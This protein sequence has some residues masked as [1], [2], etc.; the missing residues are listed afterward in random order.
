MFKYALYVVALVAGVVVS[1]AACSKR[2][3]QQVETEFYE[4]N[5][6]GGDDGRLLR[7]VNLNNQGVGSLRWALAQTGA[8]KIIFDVGGVIDL[9]EKSLKIREAHVTIAGETAPSPG[10]TLIKGGLRI[11]TH[12]V[13]V[14]HLMIRPGDAG[15]SKGQGWKPDG[16]TI[17]GSKARHVVIDH[18]SVTWAV[19]E[20]IAV[21]GPADKGAEATAGKVLI[22]NSIIAEALSNA[23]HPEG[24]HSKGILIHNNVQHVSLVNNLLAH[25]RR[26]NPYFKAGTTGI[27]IGNIIYNPGKRAIHMSSGRADASLPTLSITGNLFIPAANTSPNLSL[28]SNY[29]KI[30]SSGNLVQGESRPITDGKSISLTAPPLQQVGINLTDTG[31]QNDFCQTLS[32]AGARPWDPDPIDIRIKTQLL[33]GEGRIIDSQSEV[34]GYPIHN[35]NNKE[36]AEAGSTQGDGMLQFDTELLRK[37]PNLCSGMM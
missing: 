21:S 5:E 32:N 15:Y 24:E 4:I 6:R 25:N 33:A 14:S 11:E 13:K 10:I 37:I 17:Y 20:N 3:T 27:V 36:T 16:I 12:N 2:A 29:G 8:R 35:V 28:I 26:R 1:L 30:Y 23:S 22:R 7:V 18:C 34:G 19:D 9:E 31:T